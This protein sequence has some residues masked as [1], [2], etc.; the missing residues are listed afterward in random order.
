M[1]QK[2]QVHAQAGQ[3]DLLITREFELPVEL[4]FKAHEDPDIFEQW[5]THEYGAT[6]IVRHEARDNG[7][8]QFNTV[9]A[10]GNVLFSAK[11]VFHKFLPNKKIIRTFEMNS[12]EFDPQLEFLDFE[13]LSDDTSMLKMQIVF[14]T[15]AQRDI[16][17]KQPFAWGLNMAHNRLQDV[18]SKLNQS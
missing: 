13:K 6:K 3:H 18:L 9:D 17:L 4:L 10:Q 16:L 2:T 7:S 14:R 15:V 8:W 11:G 5:M 1:E 12:P